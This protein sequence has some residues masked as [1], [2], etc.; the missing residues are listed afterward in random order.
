MAEVNLD[1]PGSGAKSPPMQS[2]NI[3]PAECRTM[4]EVRDGI[5]RID[6][7]VVA[8]IAERFRYMDAAARIKQDRNVVRDEARKQQVLDNVGRHAKAAGLP[9]GLLPNLYE[10]LIEASIAYE[11]D[12][13]DSMRA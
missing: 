13:F 9:D 7:Q 6:A 12:R 10:M 2:P 4:T 1:R 11:L 5:D 3:Q 8:L